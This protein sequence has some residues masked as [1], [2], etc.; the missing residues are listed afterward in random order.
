VAARGIHVND[1]DCVVHYDPPSDPKDYVHRSGRTARAGASGTVVTLVTPEQRRAM[2]SL[3]RSLGISPQVAGEVPSQSPRLGALASTQRGRRSDRPARG[4]PASAHRGRSQGGNAS[5]TRVSRGSSG[6]RQGS[7]R[8]N[9]TG[10]R[11]R[12]R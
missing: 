9:T 3:W 8:S 10:S 6:R 7:G 11:R 1:V 4:R 12:G 2:E 5:S